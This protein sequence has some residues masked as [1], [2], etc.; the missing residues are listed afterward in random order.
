VILGTLIVGLVVFGTYRGRAQDRVAAGIGILNINAGDT[1]RNVT[2]SKD[3][4]V[5]AFIT[6]PKGTVLSASDEH[7]RPKHLGGGKFEF[8]GNFELRALPQTD[9]PPNADGMP[10]V[11]LMKR[12]SLVLSAQGVDVILE[13]PAQQ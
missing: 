12:A 7:R 3:G 13:R 11:E 2:V 6:L 10:A 9:V 8:H 4:K 5:L 1:D